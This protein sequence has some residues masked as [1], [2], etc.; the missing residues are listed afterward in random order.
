MFNIGLTAFIA[1]LESKSIKINE[2]FLNSIK[3]GYKEIP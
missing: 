3:D 1:D 2:Y